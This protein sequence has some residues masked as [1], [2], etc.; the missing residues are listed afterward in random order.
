MSDPTEKP[1][2]GGA[3]PEEGKPAAPDTEQILRMLEA[4]MQLTRERRMAA[5]RK[6]KSSVSLVALL[7][8]FLF[9]IVALSFVADGIK[10]SMKQNQ[11]GERR[12]E[13]VNEPQNTQPEESPNPAP[14]TQP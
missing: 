7:I 9:F 3:A 13:K 10:E 12:I 14:K 8:G 2:G 6:Q 11:K 4:E 5:D 1:A